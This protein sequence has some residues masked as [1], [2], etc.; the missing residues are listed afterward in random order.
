MEAALDEAAEMPQDSHRNQH[1]VL[2]FSNTRWLL[3]TFPVDWHRQQDSAYV[4]PK[5]LECTD[6]V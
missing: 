3:L 2:L 4:Q 6:A 1:K 5:V